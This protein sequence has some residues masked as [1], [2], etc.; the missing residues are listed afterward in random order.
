MEEIKNEVVETEAKEVAT[1]K[2]SFKEKLAERKQAKKDDKIRALELKAD[3][4]K[5]PEN[6]DERK[7]ELKEIRKRQIKRS[8]VPAAIVAGATVGTIVTVAKAAGG[9]N[10][11]DSSEDESPSED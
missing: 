7:A 5:N 2:K 9:N 10:D 8:I 3:L 11:Q 1:V 4:M 6:P